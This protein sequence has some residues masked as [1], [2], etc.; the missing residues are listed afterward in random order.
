MSEKKP[1]EK[2]LMNESELSS[3][4]TQQERDNLQRDEL[5][6]P[7]CCGHSSKGI[8]M[9]QVSQLTWGTWGLTLPVAAQI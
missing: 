7:A 1:S 9:R 5:L 3:K 4:S 2:I 8:R 6:G